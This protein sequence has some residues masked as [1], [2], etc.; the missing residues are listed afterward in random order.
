M[1]NALVYDIE[2]IRAIPDSKV[3]NEEGIEYCKGW[4]DHEHMGVSVV[5]AYDFIESRYHVFCK[6]NFKEFFEI[7]HERKLLIGFN[8]IG[9]DDK[10]LSYEEEY[11]EESEESDIQSYDILQEMWTILG[12]RFKGS[13][14]DN[15]C[16][17]NG[18]GSKSG[19]GALAPIQWQRGQIGSV[20]NY[21]LN[22]VKLTRDL[23]VLS[24][25]GPIK[26][27][28]GLLKLRRVL[29]DESYVGLN[30]SSST[31]M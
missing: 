22:D 29:N 13:G 11:S 26:S 12:R 30:D 17:L 27:P 16:S 8:T 24:Q 1:I 31:G 21:C 9:F 5:C 4:G 25:K 19:N 20:I 28:V 14:L 3:P 10:V 18:I 15:I 2:I 23:F 6:D 7:L